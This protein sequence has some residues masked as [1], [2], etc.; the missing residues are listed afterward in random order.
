VVAESRRAEEMAET[1]ASPPIRAKI[2][3]VSFLVLI[4]PI[5]PPDCRPWH[6]HSGK[7]VRVARTINAP[8]PIAIRPARRNRVMNKPQAER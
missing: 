1:A 4:P 2:M 8:M 7:A 3:T 6:R 5:Q